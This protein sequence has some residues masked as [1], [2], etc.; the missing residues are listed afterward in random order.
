MITIYTRPGC[1]PCYATKRHLDRLGL[2]YATIP[3][4]V[5]EHAAHLRAMGYQSLPVVVWGS[6]HWSGYR[7]DLIQRA[8][9][10]K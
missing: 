9:E 4:E 5:P 3:A 1:A 10:E 6:H 8:M 2:E 7:P